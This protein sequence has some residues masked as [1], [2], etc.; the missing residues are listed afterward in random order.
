MNKEY[1]VYAISASVSLI[2]YMLP[3]ALSFSLVI[4]FSLPLFM[5]PLVACECEEIVEFCGGRLCVCRLFLA[6][7]ACWDSSLFSRGMQLLFL[8]DKPL[9]VT[10]LF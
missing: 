4:L 6:S 8:L 10:A 5:P 1:T 9:K 3:F 7:V 2:Y